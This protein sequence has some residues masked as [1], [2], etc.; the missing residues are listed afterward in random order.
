MKNRLHQERDDYQKAVREQLLGLRLRKSSAIEDR[1]VDALLSLWKY[2]VDAGPL[3]L[4][5]RISETI[6]YENLI[7]AAS[8]NNDEAKKCQALA[9]G[10]WKMAGLEN[11]KA[12]PSI[13]NSRLLVPKIVWATFSAYTT[14]LTYTVAQLAAARSGVGNKLLAEPKPAIDM[15][16]NVLPHFEKGLADHGA[17]F[18]AFLAND[19]RE[20]LFDE[21][22]RA[23][24]D[25]TTEEK[26]TERA[27]AILD[28][29]AKVQM[30]Q[31][32][33]KSAVEFLKKGI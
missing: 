12:D 25:P 26:E 30:L 6:N 3:H 18:L 8:K 28:A 24:D 23:L 29:V 2:S 5:A 33:E 22:S 4:L 15:V 7:D 27:T 32:K 19:L 21:I 10:I 17:S 13:G 16:R 1:R 20:K 31:Q 14:A 9:D 11:Y